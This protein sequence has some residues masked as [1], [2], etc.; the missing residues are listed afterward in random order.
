MIHIAGGGLTGLVALW[1]LLNRG[2]DITLIEA[3]AEIGLPTRSPGWLRDSDLLHELPQD[4]LESS[5]GVSFGD[6]FGFRRGWFDRRLA[7]HL[8]DGGVRISTRTE[9]VIRDGLIHLLG[10]GPADDGP[11]AGPRV[12]DALGS[13]PSLPGFDWDSEVLRGRDDVIGLEGEALIQWEGGVCIEQDV[14]GE[15]SI[16]IP[17][18]GGMVE[19][20]WRAGQEEAPSIRRGFIER[21]TGWHPQ[22]GNLISADEAI[23]RGCRLA[24]AATSAWMG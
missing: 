17:R 15:P 16:S 14:E 10:A 11:I 3:R 18:Q 24:D 4:L 21:I 20:W 22:E 13:V 8:G 23:L 6:G 5:E 7:Q 19:L 2:F 1:Q 9:V 12:L